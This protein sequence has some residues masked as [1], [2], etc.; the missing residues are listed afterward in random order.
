MIACYLLHCG[1]CISASEAL[2]FYGTVRTKDG[3]GV[4]IPSQRRYVGYYQLLLEN[5]LQ[6][7]F[8]TRRRLATLRR[9]VGDVGSI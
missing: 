3:K 2:T 8:P 4:T 9:S 7:P 6:L 5:E 1:K